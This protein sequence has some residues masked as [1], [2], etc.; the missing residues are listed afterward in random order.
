VVRVGVSGVAERLK[1]ATHAKPRVLEVER[2]SLMRVEWSAL[3]RRTVCA[4]SAGGLGPV[5]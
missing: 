4:R 3:R 5:E 1:L 2:P